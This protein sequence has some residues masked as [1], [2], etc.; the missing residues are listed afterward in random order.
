VIDDPELLAKQSAYI[1]KIRGLYKRE[2]NAGFVF[3]LVGVLGL[4][5]V[6]FRLEAP[7]WA[8]W[9]PLGIVALGWAL[10]AW[11]IYKRTAWVRAHPFDPDA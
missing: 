11:S 2:R 4:V 8:L 9:A 3:C 1:D 6:R 10:F 7:P 5:L